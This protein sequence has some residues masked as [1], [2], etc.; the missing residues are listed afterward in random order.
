MHRAPS[1]LREQEQ[2]GTQTFRDRP[3]IVIWNSPQKPPPPRFARYQPGQGNPTWEAPHE[4]GHLM[5]LPDQYSSSQVNRQRATTPN[6]GFTNNV[7][8]A[9]GQTGATQQDIGN[10]INANQPWYS[11]AIDSVT[12]FFSPTAD[13]SSEAAMSGAAGGFLLY[14]NKP[15]TNQMQSVYSK[16]AGL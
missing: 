16:G 8:G 6:P 9:Y 2:Q 15:N 13:S 4:A 11:R 5:G 14:P 1:L 12:N 10:V 7:M 3:R